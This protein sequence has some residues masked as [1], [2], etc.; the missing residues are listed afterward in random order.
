[1]RSLQWLIASVLI[2][3]STGGLLAQ[4]GFHGSIVGSVTDASGALVPG[5]DVI[6]TNLLTGV[7]IRL[8][9]N[10]RGFYEA[11]NLVPGTYKV[12]AVRTGFR[13][14]VR[15]DVVL[16]GGQ[17]VRADAQLSVGSARQQVVV[18]GAASLINTE[19]ATTA[20]SLSFT[21]ALAVTL[22]DMPVT[23][24]FPD[25]YYQLFTS[26]D[27]GDSA[28]Q[29]GG[30]LPSQNGEV[31]DGMRVEG[32]DNYV[33]GSRGLARPGIDSVS[34]VNVTLSTP[35]A[36][37]PNPTSIETV[38]Q[39]GTNV[40]HGS[41][42][43]IYGGQSLNAGNYFTHQKEPFLVNQYF[44][45]FGGPIQ[46]DKTFFFV[47]FQ[48]M[49]YDSVSTSF[50]TLPTA[51]MRAGDLSQFLNPTFLKASGFTAPIV[52]TDPTTG[53]PFPGNIVP[54]SL[55]DPVAAKVLAEYPAPTQNSA[56]SPFLNNYFGAGTLVRK[57]VDIDTR[58]DHYFNPNEHLYGRWTYF[59][60]PNGGS[61][62]VPDF[63]G[64]YFIV[65]T[66]ILTVHQ[67][68]VIN[69]SL[70]NDAMFG[71]FRE[72]DPLGAGLFT[73]TTIPWNQRLGI[74]GVPA[75]QDVGF[76]YLTFSQLN[77]TTP[78]DYG[79]GN[80]EEQ[81]WEARDD[82][83]W[84]H[85]RHVVQFGFDFR[86]DAQGNSLPGGN[87]PFGGSCNFGCMSF[88]G[89]WTGMDF[90]D[91]LLGLPDTSSLAIEQ[92]ADTRNRNEWA[93]YIEDG[94]KVT[95][96]LNV[97][98]GLRYDYYPV[99]SSAGGLESIFLPQKLELVVPS[100]KSLSKIPSFANIPMPVVTA[101]EAGLPS[102]LLYADS[103]W[104]PR[105][106]LAY[107]FAP[108]TVVRAGFGLYQTPLVNV[109]LELLTGP[110]TPTEDFP[111]AQPP[112][113]GVPVI[114]LDHPYTGTATSPP[115]LNYIGSETH[116]NDTSNYDYNLTVERQVGNTTAFSV[117]YE[118]KS[119]VMPWRPNINAVPPSLIP[120]SQSR[121]PFPT[122][123][124]VRFLEN[125]AHYWYNGLR[126]NAR[127]SFAKGLFFDATYVWSKD[128][129]DLGGITGS[130]AGSSENPF[131]RDRDI[132]VNGYDPPQAMSLNYVYKL[133]FGQPGGRLAFAA[134]GAGRVVNQIIKGWEVAG[135]YLFDT[136]P[137]L[138]PTGSY[139]NAADQ[140]IDAP[141]TNSTSGRPDC[142]GQT[143]GPT[144]QQAAEGYIFNPGA[145][146][147]LIAPGTYGTCGTGILYAAPGT[148]TMNEA[149]YRS[150][151]IPWF[152]GSDHKATF[153]VGVQMFN[154]LNH[155][156]VPAPETSLDSPLFGKDILNKTGD[157]RTMAL[158]GRID[159]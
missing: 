20:S 159:F 6:V 57:E 92:P 14:Y 132:G 5:A 80:F 129:D 31:Q 29:Q 62:S 38:M 64:N 43:Y 84:N 18:T 27:T 28:F 10:S 60:S 131:N 54:S 94:I 136:A 106:G 134:S 143:V 34:E 59:H 81:I 111:V 74:S 114:A 13:T 113:G 77:I 87:Q 130:P 8:T 140:I 142:T 16:T 105:V 147:A 4:E 40:W 45:S 82:A 66:N 15:N 12:T 125:G 1:M 65:N 35:S 91:F 148:V 90:G 149:F 103:N 68:S 133:P 21:H 98:L 155:S 97:E 48:G 120:F 158:Q 144:S 36:A 25:I 58:V 95:P 101:Q 107:R 49:H 56:T 124:S 32:Q 138:T 93:A 141:N 2:L 146:S 156:N 108:N 50:S 153:R 61:S 53:Q 128:M 71:Y 11:L 157:T 26:A 100:Q 112:P 104:G 154:F 145:F 78:V 47:G 44:G 72:D 122:L 73:N 46:K 88:N 117:E 70:V 151:P 127:H 3:M 89:R 116:L 52:V 39:S 109:G 76:P 23:N 118:G 75:D 79:P 99:V 24:I 67:S 33:G 41:L 37:S 69:P 96:S 102:S 115:V 9:T 110:F 121:L 86:R 7:T 17:Q 83:T 42:M 150:F 22:P 30:S 135:N 137:P 123:G 85:G 119:A 139:R 126:L 51:Q 63:G 19:T 55:I 152:I